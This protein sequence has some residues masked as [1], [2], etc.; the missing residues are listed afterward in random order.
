MKLFF[1]LLIIILTSCS[2]LADES[3]IFDFSKNKSSDFLSVEEAFDPSYS[4]SPT[5]TSFIIKFDIQPG[6]YLYQSKLS[7]SS[8]NN[9][10]L[11]Y[12]LPQGK[13]KYDEFFGDQII[14]SDPLQIQ[15]NFKNAI[16]PDDSILVSYQGCSEKGLCYPPQKISVNLKNIPDNKLQLNSF[17][18]ALSSNIFQALL[19]FF[20]AGLLLSL[21][22]CVLPLIPVMLTMLSKINKNKGAATAVYVMGICS[23]YSIIGLI[24]SQTGSLLSLYFQ[25]DYIIAFSSILFLIFAASMFDLYELSLPSSLQTF[26]NS[27]ANRINTQRYIGIYLLGAISSLI[28]SPCVAPPLASGILFISQNGD[29]ST[30]VISLF[31]MALGMS[32]PMLIL[33]FTS[34]KIKLR[35]GNF[36]VLI[37]NMI[38][39]I[40]IAT[41]IFI[42]KPLL[43]DLITALLYALL[44]FIIIAFL[45][46]KIQTKYRIFKTLITICS[47]IIIIMFSFQSLSL[48]LSKTSEDK[49]P[50]TIID[51]M[52]LLNESLKATDKPVMIDFYADWCAACLELHEYTFTDP[53]VLEELKRFKLIKIDVTSFTKDDQLIMEKYGIYGPPSIVF[54]NT[55][56]SELKSSQIYGFI[57]AEQFLKTIKEIQ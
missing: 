23:T 16:S 29:V 6:Y 46:I 14:Y 21:T 18:T 13:E 34:S 28:L 11:N 57:G 20:V 41:G 4:I 45:Y 54:Y 22:P 43:G 33:G 24:A 44:C 56:K 40:L 1:R 27:V 50:F 55:E 37:K 7:F 52:G 48:K 12:Q 53:N 26:F 31:F 15:I 38:G 42:G 30:G 35:S 17:E 9:A 8:N 10:E 39:F 25:N 2:V 19:V 5:K 47:L 51:N 32:F 49:L 36:N 3:N